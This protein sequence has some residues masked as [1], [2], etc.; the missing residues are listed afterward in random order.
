[1]LERRHTD[2]SVP[3]ARPVLTVRIAVGRT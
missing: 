2:Y 1:L 3:R